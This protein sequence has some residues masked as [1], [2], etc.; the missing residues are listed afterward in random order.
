MMRSAHSDVWCK[1]C[2]FILLFFVG[3]VMALLAQRWIRTG[4]GTQIT[5]WCCARRGQA[6][7][8]SDPLRCSDS[9]GFAFARDEIVCTAACASP[10]PNAGPTVNQR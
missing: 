7:M 3:V 6:C 9:G 10:L 5:G 2:F 8:Q 4:G 1:A